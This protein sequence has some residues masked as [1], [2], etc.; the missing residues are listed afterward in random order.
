M[1]VVVKVHFFEGDHLV[2]KIAFQRGSHIA[3]TIGKK[4]Q[5]VEVELS[6]EQVSRQ[7]AQLI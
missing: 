2:N 6:A 3:V 4:G 5:N 1:S 7:H